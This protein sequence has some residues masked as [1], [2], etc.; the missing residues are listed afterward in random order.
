M[1]AKKQLKSKKKS[2]FVFYSS[3][4]NTMF[5]KKQRLV[6]FKAIS[7]YLYKLIQ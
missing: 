7:L 5:L 6:A 4:T 3:H 2:I 1:Q